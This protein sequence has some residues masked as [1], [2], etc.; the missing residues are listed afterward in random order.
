V[1]A[2]LRHAHSRSITR[3]PLRQKAFRAHADLI[4]RERVQSAKA[5]FV[6]LLPRSREFIRPRTGG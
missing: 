2:D 6:W 1:I 4:P 3:H 5:D